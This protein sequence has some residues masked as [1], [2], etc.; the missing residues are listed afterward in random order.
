[1]RTFKRCLF[2]GL[3]AAMVA[4]LAAQQTKKTP[5]PYQSRNQYEPS[6]PA[7][8]GQKLLQQFV[9]DWTFVDTFYGANGHTRVTNGTCKQTMIEGGKFLESDFTFMPANRPQYTGM[10]ISGFDPATNKFTTLWIDATRPVMS[11]RQSDGTFDDK[12]IVLI[13]TSL[14]PDAVGRKTIARAHLDAQGRLVYDHMLVNPDGS[15][16][17]MFEI[18]FTRK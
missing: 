3:L 7:G 16:Q 2:A 10:G 1:M 15:E 14:D 11:I 6:S 17:K 8:A 9:G 4:L 18:L 12:N 13:S 5:N